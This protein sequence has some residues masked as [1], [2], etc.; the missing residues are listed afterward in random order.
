MAYCL[1][2]AAAQRETAHKKDLPA[3]GK[4]DNIYVHKAAITSEK[5]AEVEKG[6]DAMNI[7]TRM[8]NA[9]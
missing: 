3:L 6:N 8:R 1:P 5:Q 2:V 7:H 9:L 4:Q